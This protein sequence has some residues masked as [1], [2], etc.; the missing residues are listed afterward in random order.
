[1]VKAAADEREAGLSLVIRS[2]AGRTD[3]ANYSHKLKPNYCSEVKVVRVERNEGEYQLF[4][5]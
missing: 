4:S 1:M 2:T 5:A 3:V